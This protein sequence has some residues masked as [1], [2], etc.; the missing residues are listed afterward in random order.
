MRPGLPVQDLI[1]RQEAPTPA[2]LGRATV[3]DVAG[4]EVDVDRTSVDSL[5]EDIA[6]VD[7]EVAIQEETGMKSV[8]DTNSEK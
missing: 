5:D 2:Q 8:R 6:T 1:M 3:G 7:M 4:E